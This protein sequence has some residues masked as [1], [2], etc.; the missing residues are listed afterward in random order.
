MVPSPQEDPSIAKAGVGQMISERAPIVA[1][2][3]DLPQPTS[4]VIKRGVVFERLR[5]LYVPVPKA[6]CTAMLWALAQASFLRE[7]DFVGSVGGEVTRAL[8]IHDM[9]R[10]PEAFRYGSRTP[11]DRQALLDADGWFRFTVVRN[12]FRRLWSAWQSKILQAEPQFI[13]KF[14][15]QTWFPE[16]VDGSAGEILKAFRDFLAA[17]HE[18]PELL[19]S[20][21]HWA[22]QVDLIE[23]DQIPYD[24]V[25]RVE[26]MDQTVDHLRRHLQRHRKPCRRA[27]G[28]RRHACRTGTTHH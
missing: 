8:T 16:T 15:S 12:P 7:G 18:N 13:R 14:S 11:E 28:Q 23:Y 2:S 10:W 22:P 19:R 5:V 3:D 6:G 27:G 24:H 20:D 17:I 21:V 26:A 9:S 4:H 1:T 25:G